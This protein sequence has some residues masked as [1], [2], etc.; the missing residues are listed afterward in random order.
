MQSFPARSPKR[1]TSGFTLIELLVVIAIIA[2]LAAILFPVFA[3]A[4]ERARQT[5]CTNNEKQIGIGVTLYM[6]EWDDTYPIAIH[7]EDDAPHAWVEQLYRYV[8]TR[9][10]NKCPS[11]S[12][13]DEEPTHTTSYFMNVYFNGGLTMADVPEPARTIYMGESSDLRKGDHYHPMLGIARMKEELSTARH[14]GGANYLF[15]DSHV[16]WMKFEPTI[17]PVNLHEIS[18]ESRGNTGGGSHGG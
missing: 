14:N 3:K 4:R 17:E 15:A 13:F 6:Q 5:S 12:G 8:K 11:D 18:A 16:K 2:I 10:L 1:R 7:K 9:D